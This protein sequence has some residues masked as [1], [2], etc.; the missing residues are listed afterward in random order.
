[1]I[2]Y[3]TACGRNIIT[4]NYSINYCL[5]LI[6][7]DNLIYNISANYDFCQTLHHFVRNNFN[8]SNKPTIFLPSQRLCRELKQV[9]L[10]E[11][12][13]SL[14]PQIKAIA[15]ID[16]ND[17]WLI[18]SKSQAAKD[19]IKNAIEEI[20]EYKV[21]SGMD[22][23]FYIA[24]QA[25]KSQ[26][27]EKQASTNQYLKL[28]YNLQDLFNDLEQ[29]NI[30]NIEFCIIDDS[31]LAQHRQITLEFLKNFYSVIKNSLAKE[32]KLL[33]G[34]FYNLIIK[35]FNELLDNYKL[36]QPVI[37][38]GSTG[39]LKINKLFIKSISAQEDGIVILNNYLDQQLDISE[40]HPQFFN[41]Q[42]LQAIEKKP[43]NII[44]LENKDFQ[45][46]QQ[47]RQEMAKYLFLPSKQLS[48]WHDI[49][50]QK[51][52]KQDI[53]SNFTIIEGKN[54]FD[55]VRKICQIAANSI[56]HSNIGIVSNDANISRLICKELAIHNISF[57][58]GIANIISNTSL[59]QFIELVSEFCSNE[60]NSHHFLAIL[61][62][63]LCH[64]CEQEEI[65]T[66]FECEII[67]QQRI[68]N[69]I[70]GIK[71]RLKDVDD[72]KLHSLFNNFYD[73]LKP[74]KQNNQ[75]LAQHISELINIIENLTKKSWLELSSSQEGGIE[76][77]EFFDKLK[78]QHDFYC[79]FSEVDKIIKNLTT[80]TSFFKQANSNLKIH[81][82]SSIEAR[83]IEFDII[84]IC[85]LNE[86]IFP[87]TTNEN[88]LGIKI[89][90][91]LGIEKSL[92][93]I[94][95]NA[96]DFCH[97][98]TNK[99]VILSRHLSCNNAPTIASQFWIRFNLFCQK[100]L[101]KP[102]KIPDEKADNKYLAISNIKENGHRHN[103]KIDQISITDL[104]K[105]NKNPYFV[106]AK[107]ILKLKDIKEIDYQPSFSEFGSF[108]HKALEVYIN[109]EGNLEINFK[110][111]FNDFFYSKEAEIIWWSKFKKILENFINDD[112][113]IESYQ[114][115]AEVAA[116]NNLLDLTI[117]G[118][119]DR[120][121]IDKSGF[122]KIF[123]YK[124]GTIPSKKDVL[125]GIE[126]QLLI[127]ALLLIYGTNQDKISNIDINKIN[128]L[129]YWKISSATKNTIKIMVDD[130]NIA[131]IITQTKENLEKIINYYLI[132][133]NR[134]EANASDEF[135]CYKHLARI[136]N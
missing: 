122:I 113:E 18:N 131:E 86:G 63:K 38:A 81:L 32:K 20:L 112:N 14:I 4:Q 134:F 67:R 54:E 31:N 58:D 13:H 73:E 23:I 90:K 128:G 26:I 100:I 12:T 87:K 41:H 114:N 69:T 35:K 75:S 111:I 124:T 135:D 17:F 66:R 132:Q 118:K 37:I 74:L 52:I 93:Q 46:S 28:A 70:L 78:Q 21:I 121:V 7:V 96:H 10:R 83:L 82:L 105:L 2:C 116:K 62:N 92:K 61:K 27:L 65:I 49:K 95:K 60:F 19:D 84:I 72:E 104:V 99:K 77:F 106:Y 1:M 16:I 43:Q 126:S 25:K 39:S 50:N 9:F 117:V 55:E 110:K 29:E 42:L 94:G 91:D 33:A 51:E 89:R 59:V 85:A 115:F 30:E 48:L 36:N 119:I 56:A 57:N 45:I 123:D 11:K 40:S 44:N 120:I 3:N 136:E 125:D 97:Y 22:E 109:K 103:I 64:Y 71:E 98:L 80:K 129:G 68:D 133:D 47:R 53:E 79:D 15:N 76:I 6:K 8:D 107:K 102:D 34:S 88:W 101:A 108:I 127:A 130:K 5:S 24:Q